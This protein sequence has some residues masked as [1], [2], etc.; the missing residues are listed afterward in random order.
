M[1]N[2]V[3]KVSTSKVG[4]EV[5]VDLGYSYEQWNQMRECIQDDI[6]NEKLWEV[7]NVSV[8]EKT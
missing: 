7:V 8:E 6:V 4:S 3:L 1:A 5:E 2:M